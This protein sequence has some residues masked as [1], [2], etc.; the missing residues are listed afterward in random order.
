ML[1]ENPAESAST[2]R[3]MLALCNHFAG[4]PL[5]VGPSYTETIPEA[6]QYA[7]DMLRP[8]GFPHLWLIQCEPQPGEWRTLATTGN[9]EHGEAPARF[10]A[11]AAT[12]LPEI[13]P[14][15]LTLAEAQAAKQV[16][17][18]QPDELSE[19]P[20]EFSMEAICYD[21]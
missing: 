6:R 19:Q 12:I 15:F 5:R 18:E 1:F 11:V 21:I 20:D 2:L 7:A 13:L 16:R 14:Q 10:I 9:A 8:E 3:E 4:R 17:R